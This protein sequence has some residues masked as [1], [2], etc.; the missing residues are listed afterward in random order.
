MYEMKCDKLCISPVRAVIAHCGG[1]SLDLKY[2]PIG[3][4]GAQAIAAPLLVSKNKLSH[5]ITS[6]MK[7][8]G[9]LWH[10]SK[11]NLFF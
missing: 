8:E 11:P 2:H 1:E 7:G 6:Q 9:I 4:L 3:P 10:F 5:K